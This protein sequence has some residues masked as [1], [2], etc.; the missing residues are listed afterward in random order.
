M[1][2]VQIFH[3]ADIVYVVVVVHFVLEET[4]TVADLCQKN[5]EV[6][7]VAIAD[8]MIEKKIVICQLRKV[9]LVNVYVEPQ[10]Q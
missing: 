8:A 1:Q 2:C 6:V 7:L 9:K 5:I 3:K 4:S 10:L